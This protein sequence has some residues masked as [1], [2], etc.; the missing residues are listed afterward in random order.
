MPRISDEQR[1]VRRSQILE[2]ARA[3]VLEHGLEA[4]SME[5]IVARSG[6]STGAVYGYFRGKDDIINAVVSEGTAQLGRELSPILT[7]PT[8]PAPP[9]F[10]ESLLRTIV[11]F[12]T[13]E[14]GADRLLVSIHGW[15]HSQSNPTLKASTRS[16]Y[17]RLRTAFTHVARRWQDTGVLRPSADTAGV[18]ELLMSLTLGFVA[19][20]ALIGTASIRAHVCALAALCDSPGRTTS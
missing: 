5:M 2:A 13:R 18:A 11:E 14:R 15:S 1:E 3:C 7:N 20:R 10:L 16:D 17:R 6:L 12:S 8:P 9:E 19:Q 4:V